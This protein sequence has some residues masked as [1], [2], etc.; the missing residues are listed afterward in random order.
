MVF[1]LLFFFFF[2]RYVFGLMYSEFGSSVVVTCF[3]L[4][5]CVLSVATY[6]NFLLEEH[7]FVVWNFFF[8]FQFVFFFVFAYLGTIIFVNFIYYRKP[9]LDVLPI[10]ASI[11]GRSAIAFPFPSSLWN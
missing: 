8:S 10:I 7:V 9:I 6:H 3:C 1:A 5:C 11:E 2:Q 4:C